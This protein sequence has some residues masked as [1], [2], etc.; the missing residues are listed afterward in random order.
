MNHA[1][2][3]I[4]NIAK[5][6]LVMAFLLISGCT[7]LRGKENQ[8]AT[9]LPTIIITN[10]FQPTSAPVF[11]STLTPTP[12]FRFEVQS[13][14]V[15]ISQDAPP[16]LDGISVVLQ[17]NKQGEMPS[18]YL[19]NMS[20][21]NQTEL[22]EIFPAASPSGK[23]LAYKDATLKSII[24]SDVKGKKLGTISNADERLRVVHWLDDTHLVLDKRRTE[25]G[26]L[27]LLPS[28]V[29][30]DIS[31][32]EQKEWVPDLP[33]INDHSNEVNWG[34]G[35]RIVISPNFEY[36]IYPAWE[37]DLPVILWNIETQQEVARIH[38]GN[39]VNSPWW[40]PDGTRFV[41][42]AP[43]R[44]ENYKNSDDNLPFLGGQELFIVN[45][46]G[47]T[48][49]LTYFTT[50]EKSIQNS[51]GWSQDGSQ[52]F[53]LLQQYLESGI[54]DPQLMAVDI[55]SEKV[56]NYCINANGGWLLSNN[57]RYIF[58]NQ[59][60]NKFQTRALLID[61]INARGWVISDDVFVSGW[62]LGD[63]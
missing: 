40:S 53:F 58:V 44:I 7:D 27:S 2:Y 63:N 31:S 11:T 12:D 10:T 36:L 48:K 17:R 34:I 37:D 54:S 14:C 22:G 59:M 41:I 6:I 18:S 24:I 26:D 51:Y 45:A 38:N 29:I 1:V 56:T 46:T 39:R 35:G 43:P 5:I 21:G 49:R 13:Q 16:K 42:S 19:L 15:Q 8:S 23:Q 30:F 3:C 9:Q 60:D 4:R 33:N 57:K 28:V 52:I 50:K 25:Y 62:I 20:T 55:N 61:I 47:K 32:G